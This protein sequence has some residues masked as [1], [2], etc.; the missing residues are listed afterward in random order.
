MPFTWNNSNPCYES[1]GIKIEFSHSTPKLGFL[2]TIFLRFNIEY[3]Y[4]LILIGL[5]PWL[6]FRS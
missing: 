4:G 5:V 2:A 3:M 1:K 6:R